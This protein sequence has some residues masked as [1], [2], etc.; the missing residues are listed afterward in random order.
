VMQVGFFIE[1][2]GRGGVE[3]MMVNTASGLARLGILVDYLAPS[4]GPYLDDLDDLVR[5]RGM[6]KGRIESVQYVHD[7]LRREKPN[8]I[9]VAKDKD[10]AL[11]L[12]AKRRAGSD[13]KV[14]MRPGT[15][16]SARLDKKLPL[17][18]WIKRRTISRLYGKAAAIVANSEAVRRDVGLITGIPVEEI[19]LIRNPVVSDLLIRRAQEPAAHQWFKDKKAPVILGVGNLHRVKDFATLIKAFALVRRRRMVRL[20]ILGEGHLKEKLKTL[21]SNLGVGEDVSFPGFI[22]NPYPF[23]RSADL[24]VLS[25]V[26]EGS[27][28]ALTEALALGTPVVATDCP[29]GVREILQQGCWG[30]IVA[31]KSPGEM[32]NAI[33]STLDNRLPAA[34]LQDAVANYTQENCARNYYAV[35]S[36]I[37]TN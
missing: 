35:V 7:Y 16:A 29:G 13:V 14:I 4:G 21:A 26:R 8:C 9:V 3:R 2:Y 31:M 10:L 32:A 18:R 22:E 15:T 12:S 23:I 24:Y 20:I 17:V 6:P 34:T 33:V 30:A 37:C 11:V 5:F 36:K 25:S 1:K 27:P 19:H 28:N